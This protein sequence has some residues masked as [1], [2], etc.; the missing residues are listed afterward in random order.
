MWMGYPHIW[1]YPYIEGYLHSGDGRGVTL[2]EG[3]GATLIW[4]CI[5]IIMSFSFPREYPYIGGCTYI[6]SEAFL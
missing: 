1:A 3:G 2:S 4:V 6:W 5:I